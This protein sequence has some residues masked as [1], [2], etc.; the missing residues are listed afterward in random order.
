MNGMC[1]RVNKKGEFSRQSAKQ[2]PRVEPSASLVDRGITRNEFEVT[3]T[4]EE[5]AREDRMTGNG[6]GQI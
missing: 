3:K 2:A 4:R 5:A 1:E 6:L